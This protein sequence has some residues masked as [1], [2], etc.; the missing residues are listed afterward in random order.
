MCVLTRSCEDASTA[1]QPL[2]Y[3]PRT[4]KNT[5]LQEEGREGN[6]VVWT[7]MSLSEELVWRQLKPGRCLPVDVDRMMVVVLLR[8]GME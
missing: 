1:Q 3:T 8:R 4:S 6:R 2:S 7:C 5:S